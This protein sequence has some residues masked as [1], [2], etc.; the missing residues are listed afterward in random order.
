MERG[1]S[2]G[3]GGV[4]LW[5]L[6][7]R[8][9]WVVLGWERP[10]VQLFSVLYLLSSPSP[11][12]VS[13]WWVVAQSR[14]ASHRSLNLAALGKELD[15]PRSESCPHPLPVAFTIFT[16]GSTPVSLEALGHMTCASSV[17]TGN[18][19]SMWRPSETPGPG[20]GT[21]VQHLGKSY[22]ASDVTSASRVDGSQA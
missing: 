12:P 14:V 10:G 19:V 22:L 13:C 8:S 4:R 17:A 7:E 1:W 21:E 16:S 20:L 3:V 2:R 11:K 15:S 9:A 18:T 5:S 6:E